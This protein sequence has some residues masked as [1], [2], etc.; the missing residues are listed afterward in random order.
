MQQLNLRSYAFIACRL[1]AQAEVGHRT[2][3]P[4]RAPGMIGWS[5][6]LSYPIGLYEYGSQ[7]AEGIN[8]RGG[9]S[10]S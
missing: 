1:L 9:T 8:L 6:Q 4:W 3:G 5:C 2:L 10:G 7:A